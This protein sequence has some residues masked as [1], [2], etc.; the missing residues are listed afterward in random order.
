M[1]NNLEEKIINYLGVDWGERRI[2]LATADSD[3]CLALPYSTV[4]SLDDLLKVITDEQIDIVVIG[5]PIKMSGER[6]NNPLWQ[7]FIKNLKNRTSKEVLLVDER[8]SSL[9]ADAMGGDAARD[10]MAASIILQTYLDKLSIS[11]AD[12]SSDNKS[13][14]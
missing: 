6:A 10:E 13:V 4:S 2:G 12:K 3:V 9:G 11:S 8:L 7:E 14:S 1:T 5:E